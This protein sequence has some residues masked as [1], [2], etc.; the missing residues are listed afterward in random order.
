L[1]PELLLLDE[2]VAGMR[3]DET[4]KVGAII[5]HLMGIGYTILVVEHNMRFIM[6]LCKR[7]LVLNY[8]IKIAEGTP[9]QIYNN[10]EVRKVYLGGDR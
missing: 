3:P 7:I 2:P 9:Q 8:G 10:P 4:D 6:N 1:E 5:K